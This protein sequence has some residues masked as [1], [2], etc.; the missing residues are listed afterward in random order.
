[1]AIGRASALLTCGLLLLIN[2]SA[3]PAPRLATS[4]FPV[5]PLGPPSTITVLNITGANFEER[6]LAL[7]A[8]GTVAKARA[9]LAVVDADDSVSYRT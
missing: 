9:D 3:N 6:V 8:V 1:M 2:T 4:P 5:S 7:S